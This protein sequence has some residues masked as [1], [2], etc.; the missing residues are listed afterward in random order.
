MSSKNVPAGMLA[1]YRVLDLSDEKGFYCGQLLGSMGADVIKIE[2]PCGDPSR[3]I[4][5]YYHDYPQAERSLYWFSYNSNK[6]GITLALEKPEGQDLFKKLCATA[7]IVVESFS[8]GYMERLGLGFRTLQGINPSLIVTSISPFGQDGPYCNHKGSD[9]VCW[10]LG[11]LL[12][13]TGD[14]DRPPVRISHINFAYLMGAMDAAWASMMALYWRGSSGRGQH[15]DVSIQESVAKTT[16]IEHEFYEATGK[17]RERGSTFYKVPNSNVVLRIVWPVKDG[18]LYLMLRGGDLG[19]RENPS[20]V[21]WMD[22]EGMAD[23]FIKSVDWSTLDWRSSTQEE[24][25]RIHDYFGLFF[26]TKTKAEVLEGA[27][28]RG[29]ILQAISSPKDIA[30]HPQLEARG[31]WQEV[32]HPELK[33][34]VKYPGRFHLASGTVNRIWR[35]AP[36]PGEHNI[37]IYSTDLGLSATKLAALKTAGVV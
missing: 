17:E 19:A 29:I 1:P 28:K 13:Q 26:L 27:L 20:I 18:Y 36:L 2:Q 8:P 33:A 24:A 31:Y 16:F 9:L 15:I 3:N 25:N 4:G 37:E 21:K 35:R 34:T 11:G 6:R 12:A 22:E 7:D 30:A 10:A 14:T 23:D 5:P 32:E